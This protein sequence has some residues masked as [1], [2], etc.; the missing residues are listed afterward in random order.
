VYK[1]PYN[2]ASGWCSIQN[3]EAPN[4]ILVLS[5]SILMWRKHRSLTHPSLNKKWPQ[6]LPHR[7]A[8]RLLLRMVLVPITLNV[9]HRFQ[10]GER[11]G[12]QS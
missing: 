8:T 3:S 6:Y 9:N 7:L 1:R 10:T 5:R 2:S 4:L 11:T 12:W